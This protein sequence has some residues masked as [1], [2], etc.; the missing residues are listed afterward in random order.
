MCRNGVGG[1]ARTTAMYVAVAGATRRSSVPCLTGTATTP[2]IVTATSVSVWCVRQSSRY[3]EGGRNASF[4]CNLLGDKDNSPCKPAMGLNFTSKF[5]KP[6][7][8]WL[9]LTPGL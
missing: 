1:P 4:F 5:Y 8:V 9:R 2:I 6:L 7:Q 3:G